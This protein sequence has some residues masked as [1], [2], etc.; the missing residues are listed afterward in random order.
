VRKT[1]H[2]MPIF[3]FGAKFIYGNHLNLAPNLNID[4]MCFVL[5]TRADIGAHACR[6]ECARV[7]E[8]EHM[9]TI[10]GFGANIIYGNHLNL[11][12]KSSDTFHSVKIPYIDARGYQKSSVHRNP[13][14]PPTVTF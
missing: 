14:S 12:P 11:A 13:N 10:Y 7:S 8:T 1:E 9:V 5:C 4:I 2:M 6:H 3:R